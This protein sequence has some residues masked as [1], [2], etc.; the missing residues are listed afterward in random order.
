MAQALEPG[1]LDGVSRENQVLKELVTIYHHLTGLALQNADVQTVVE[2]LARRMAC[3]VALVDPTLEILAAGAPDLNAGAAKERARESITRTRLARV[4]NAVSETRRA[5]RLP[6]VAGGPSS[7]VAPVLVGDDILAYLLTVEDAGHHQGEDTSLLVTEHAATICGVIMGRERVVAAAAGRVRDDLIE[8]L[9]LGRARDQDEAVR[10]AQHLGYD[11]SRTYQ[12][13]SLSLED[14]SATGLAAAGGRDADLEA[15]R[16]RVFDSLE[17]FV[18]AREPGAVVAVHAGEM[19]VLA[20]EGPLEVRQLATDCLAQ[21]RRAFPD[22]VVSAG[23]GGRCREPVG[24]AQAY[25]QARRTTEIARRLGRDG[26]VVAFEDLGIHR[27]LLQVPD[28]GELRAFAD[29]V[30]GELSA[31]ERRSGAG[32]LRTLAVYLR[33]NGSLQRAAALLHVHP[34]TVTYRLNRVAEITGLDLG[35]YRDRLMAEV[36]LEILEAL[37]DE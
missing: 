5:L 19:V 3:R 8:G 10:W 9:L 32:Y 7:V 26:E 29:E 4:L 27:L 1:R 23:V 6:A 24:I 2:L 13:V 17:R 36:A 11:V 30:L 28:L 12:V 31:Y 35:Q 20:P 14:A 34:N 25:A 15:R 18:A 21:S 37:R 16:R 33:E 22:A